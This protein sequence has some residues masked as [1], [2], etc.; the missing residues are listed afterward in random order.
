MPKDIS[1][2]EV[3]LYAYCLSARTYRSRFLEKQTGKLHTICVASIGIATNPTNNTYRLVHGEGD[4]LPGL[5]I[6]VYAKTAVM[7][8]HSA[9]MH[10]DRMTIA[11]A[12]SEVMGDKIENIYYKS[13]TTLPFKADLFPENGF[14][15]GGS[16]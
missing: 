14:L 13:E 2:S 6:D 8:A 11:E 12:L 5:V 10:V 1:R 9:G 7:Q 16:Q 4:N 3:L 15:K